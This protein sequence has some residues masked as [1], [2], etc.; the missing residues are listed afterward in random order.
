MNHWPVSI[1]VD[2]HRQ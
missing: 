2:T 1:V